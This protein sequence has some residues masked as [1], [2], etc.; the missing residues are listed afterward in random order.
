MARS[1]QLI[2][3]AFAGMLLLAGCLGGLS[4]PDGSGSSFNCSPV[5]NGGNNGES[6]DGRDS[7]RGLI[8]VSEE[9]QDPYQEPVSV[10][11]RTLQCT[12]PIMSTIEQWRQGERPAQ[13]PIEGDR[14]NET[15]DSF[16]KFEYDAILGLPVRLEDGTVLL[17]DPTVNG[18]G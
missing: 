5:E 7:H 1:S 12:E 18:T 14:F 3:I 4:G 17:V 8:I 11:N 6:H 15:R 2:I 13:E 10:S 16:R 9:G